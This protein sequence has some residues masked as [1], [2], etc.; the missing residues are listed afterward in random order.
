MLLCHA[1][2]SELLDL[3]IQVRR[4][5]TNS[6]YSQFITHLSRKNYP[7]RPKTHPIYLNFVSS[8]IKKFKLSQIQHKIFFF[9]THIKPY[10]EILKLNR[11]LN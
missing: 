1:Q 11:M 3:I 4:N 5:I 6:K 8:P 7:A 10:T 2:L 9:S